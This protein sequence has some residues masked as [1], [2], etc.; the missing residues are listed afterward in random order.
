MHL[1]QVFV[2]SFL[3]FKCTLAAFT[4][5]VIKSHKHNVCMYLLRLNDHSYSIGM[6]HVCQFRICESS[7][8]NI[9]LK[10]RILIVQCQAFGF[11]KCGWKSIFSSKYNCV[12]CVEVKLL[13]YSISCREKFYFLVEALPER[14]VLQK[15]S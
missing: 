13:C 7:S 8:F 10:C 3:S 11:C 1:L 6:E 15:V 14:K 9:A 12:L 4:Q 2:G 5:N